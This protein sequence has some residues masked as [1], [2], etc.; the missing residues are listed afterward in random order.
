MPQRER[1]PEEERWRDTEIVA[2]AEAETEAAPRVV[3]GDV[4][5]RRRVDPAS[6]RAEVE[7]KGASARELKR[8]G[9]LSHR[10]GEPQKQRYTDTG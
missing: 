10:G 7:E 8:E 2:E 6:E 1:K 5:R 9:T 4:W 3:Q